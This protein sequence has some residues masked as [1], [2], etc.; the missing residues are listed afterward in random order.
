MASKLDIGNA[1]I[2]AYAYAI[3]LTNELAD[4][5]DK[6]CFDCVDASSIEC[7]LWL[8]E[9]LQNRIDRDI[10]DNDTDSL[11]EQLVEATS[12]YYGDATVDIN[13]SIPYT[14]IVM[15]GGGGIAQWGFI[16][17]EITEQAD[18]MALFATKADIGDGII[19]PV[20]INIS[21][22]N[23]IISAQTGSTISWKIGT[24]IIEVSS[25]QTL[26]IADASN[27]YFR[28][29]WIAL[30][31]TGMIVV[32]GVETQTAAT[33]PNLSV[34]QIGL[35][36]I[37]IYGDIINSNPP[38]PPVDISAPSWTVYGNVP[39]GKY[40]N[41]Q[42]VPAAASAFEQYK[43]AWTNIPHPDYVAPTAVLS[44]TPSTSGLEIGQSV[45][46]NLSLA[47]NQNNAGAEMSRTINKNGSPLGGTTDTITI[48]S[49]PIVYQ[50]NVV[51]GQGAVLNNAA[52][53]PDPVGRIEAGNVNSNSISYSGIYPW[54]WLKRNT[55]ITAADMQTA[56][57]NGT[58]TKVIGSSAGTLNVPYAPNGE[59]MA[60]AY[61]AT[62]P[63]K[64]KWFVTQLSQGNI[65]GG[66]FGGQTTLAVDSP[67]GRWSAINFK[68]HV[69][70]LLTNPSATTIELRNS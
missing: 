25:P 21:G 37:D 7:L 11:Y 53:I 68:I 36:I 5:H 64:T 14:I 65:P 2:R 57:A 48:A 13:A 34:G 58:A 1:I 12:P 35:A 3:Q 67:D 4:E 43:E 15:G 39:F 22:N 27:N 69:T 66:V 26:P 42:V 10:L 70:G 9:E 49:T 28:K 47:F 63:T 19:T 61:I 29:D 33:P 52:G 59:H 56:I 40:G 30:T 45:N 38:Q 60:V 23:V 46:V 18:L 6:G 31:T 32:Q 44:S 20:D 24:Q 55:P 8:S 62:D 16:T 51:Y 41:L 54:F 50:G 17:G